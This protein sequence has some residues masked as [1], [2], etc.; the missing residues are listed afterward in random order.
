MGAA[1]W[2]SHHLY[3]RSVTLSTLS[4]VSLYLPRP[5]VWPSILAVNKD[6]RGVA[7]WGLNIELA[8]LCPFW[9]WNDP[10]KPFH[11]PLVNM[12]V[13]RKIS[14]QTSCGGRSSNGFHVEVVRTRLLHRQFFEIERVPTKP[15]HW[16]QG[17]RSRCLWTKAMTE[18]DWWR[19]HSSERWRVLHDRTNCNW[20]TKPTWYS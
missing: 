11:I 7:N 14:S 13:L 15:G 3:N 5:L 4:I 16:T 2:S 19:L 20:T 18:H 6:R 10:W 1:G 17:I 12:E 8:G 9:T